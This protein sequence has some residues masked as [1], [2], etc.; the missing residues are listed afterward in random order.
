M[1]ITIQLDSPESIEALAGFAIFLRGAQA[2]Y[3]K[4][5]NWK[6]QVPVEWICIDIKGRKFKIC[7]TTLLPADG[8]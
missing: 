2:I 4:K 7:E 3:E 1:K 8:Q 5:K 6:L